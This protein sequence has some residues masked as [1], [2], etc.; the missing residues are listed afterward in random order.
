MFNKQAFA[1]SGFHGFIV[2][3]AC[4][5]IPW[6]VFHESINVNGRYLLLN[7]GKSTSMVVNYIAESREIKVNIY[8]PTFELNLVVT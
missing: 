7:R 1:L 6:G 5:F 4:M 8:K 3:A 2:A